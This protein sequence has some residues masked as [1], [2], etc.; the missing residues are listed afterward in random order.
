MIKEITAYSR[1]SSDS[2]VCMKR[3]EFLTQIKWVDK[4]CNYFLAKEQQVQ[5]YCLHL[6]YINPPS[7]SFTSGKYFNEQLHKI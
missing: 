1:S 4:N 7:F 2:N 6:I 3:N 5:L